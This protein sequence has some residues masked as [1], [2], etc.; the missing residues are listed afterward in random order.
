MFQLCIKN[1]VAFKH[2]ISIALEVTWPDIL[3][4]EAERIRT[5]LEVIPPDPNP[6][7]FHM[8]TD[9]L[10]DIAKCAK[11]FKTTNTWQWLRDDFKEEIYSIYSYVRHIA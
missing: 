3:P 5:F 7:I 10:L 2:A 8:S 1:P 4:Q 9:T 6:L 11:Y